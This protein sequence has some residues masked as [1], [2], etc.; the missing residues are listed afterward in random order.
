M[1]QDWN[2]N[3]ALL[4]CG[5][6]KEGTEHQQEWVLP[7]SSLALVLYQELQPREAGHPADLP[8]QGFGPLAY[9]PLSLTFLALNEASSLFLLMVMLKAND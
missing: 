2:L 9:W 1:G 3:S 8:L 7:P 4:F 5:L 6:C